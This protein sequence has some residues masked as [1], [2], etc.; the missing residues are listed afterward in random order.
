MP[1][2]AV[3]AAV[4][5]VNSS[6][7]DPAGVALTAGVGNGGQIVGASPELTVLRVSNLTAGAGTF[8][9]LAGS[10]PLA[11]SSGLGGLTVN[12][13][14]TSVVFISPDE[15]ARFEQPD[16]SLIFECSV[17]MTVTA[18]KVNRH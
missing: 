15:S 11:L 8:T 18:F 13:G 9:L 10:Q 4:L 12:V 1:R 6:L 5:L 7:A 16:G 3:S 14:A 2:S 17:A